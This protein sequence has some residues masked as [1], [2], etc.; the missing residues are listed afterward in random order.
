MKTAVQQYASGTIKEKEYKEQIDT[1]R[2]KY[3]AA[4]NGKTESFNTALKTEINRVTSDSGGTAGT[5]AAGSF[6]EKEWDRVKVSV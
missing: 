4:T 2:D 3:S 1:A 5:A 6:D